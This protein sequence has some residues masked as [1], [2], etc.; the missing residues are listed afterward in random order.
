MMFLTSS[1]SKFFKTLSVWKSQKKSHSHYE[2][3]ELRLHF[4]LTKVYWKM[5]KML[6][7]VS[8]GKTEACGQTVLPDRSVFH[9]TQIGGKC[10]NSNATFWVI[11]KQCD[12]SFNIFFAIGNIGI[13]PTKDI[14]VIVMKFTEETSTTN[15][16]L[17]DLKSESVWVGQESK[18]L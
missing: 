14:I 6:N 9:R 3:S 16:W 18:C 15:L 2:R 7:L 11:F 5:P 10:Q 17:I 1:L 4:E 8:F 13:P 12:L